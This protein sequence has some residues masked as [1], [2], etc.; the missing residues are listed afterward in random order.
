MENPVEN[1]EN[2]CKITLFFKKN[3][4]K[5]RKK[6]FIYEKNLNFSQRRVVS[7]L[8]TAG[9]MTR[10]A[11]RAAFWRGLPAAAWLAAA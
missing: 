11:F 8:Q 1:V 2:P 7:P 10:H 3:R 6:S 4:E 9:I 5:A